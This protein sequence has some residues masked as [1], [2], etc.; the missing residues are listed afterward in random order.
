MQQQ[1]CVQAVSIVASSGDSGQA[2]TAEEGQYSAQPHMAALSP[3]CRWHL[4]IWWNAAAQVSYWTL[5]CRHPYRWSHPRLWESVIANFANVQREEQLQAAFDHR[6]NRAHLGA[7]QIN[8]A[9]IKSLEPDRNM[10]DTIGPAHGGVHI[11]H[12]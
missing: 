5:L 10:S 11:A 6:M 2:L 9:A 12:R 7:H 1:H 8:A 3:S 4:L